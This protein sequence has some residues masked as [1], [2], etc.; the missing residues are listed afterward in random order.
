MTNIQIV[1]LLPE[2]WPLYKEIRLE[3]LL[4]EPQA[5]GSGYA[6]VHQRPDSY[7]QERL[8]DAQAG[9][10][11]WLLFAKENERMVGMIGAY[12]SEEKD[13]VE[14][15]AVYVTR[16]KRGRGIAGALMA[17][18]LEEIGRSN[19]HRKAVLGVNA[20]QTA[21]V[22]LYQ[23]YGFQIVGE[24]EGV[25]GDGKLHTSYIMEKDLNHKGAMR[26]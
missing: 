16:E 22:A 9:E 17:A 13:G 15:I 5:F 6:E 25:M 1:K 26:R 20:D 8:K 19:I 14:I 10:K 3:S 2:E 7:W 11:S 4:A 12:C 21:A 24:K 23:R 18:I